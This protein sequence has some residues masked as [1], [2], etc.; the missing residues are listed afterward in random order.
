MK[1][2]RHL[3][4]KL[5]SLENLQDAYQKAKKHK[6]KSPAVIK[7]EKHWRLNLINLHK[8]L[9]TRTYQPQPLKTFILR[10]PKTRTICV[11]QFRDRI[12][13][14]ALVNILQPI[15]EP[16]FIYDSYASRKNKGT[17]PALKRFNTFLKKVTKN[18]KLRSDARN[19]ND[20]CGFVLKADIKHYFDTVDH[21]I[22]LKIINRYIKDEKVLWLI[23]LILNNHYSKLPGKGS[24]NQRFADLSSQAQKGMPLG[25]WT[26]Q[27]FANIYLDELDQYI[28][29]KLKIKYYLRYVDDFVI[30]HQS[31]NMLIRYKK[32]IESFLH[33]LTLELHPDKC[34]IIPLKRGISFLGFRCFYYY[35]LVRQRNIRKI[36]SKLKDM[37]EFYKSKNIDAKDIQETLRGWNAY[38]MQGNTYKLR[39]ILAITIKQELMRPT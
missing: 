16:R 23:R 12:V 35:K 14:H 39:E 20:V 37:L 8:E 26:S 11:S 6:S 4:E 31:K 2:F 36:Y 28:K 34:K 17:F 19:A 33:S 25:N 13:H 32:Q 22:L 5:I 27:F 7:F 18:G 1:T 21:K 9:K 24:A 38:A 15:F 29:H 10:D 30:L 3:F